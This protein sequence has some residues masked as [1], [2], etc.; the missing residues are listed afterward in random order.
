[1][2]YPS[3]PF[4][5]HLMPK[6]VRWTCRNSLILPYA[7]QTYS[8]YIQPARGFVQPECAKRISRFKGVRRLC[9]LHDL[10]YPGMCQMVSDPIN[11]ASEKYTCALERRGASPT[12]HVA[13]HLIVRCGTILDS[14]T[15]RDA[16]THKQK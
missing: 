13:A 6:L 5:S 7:H 9:T 12:I 16:Q 3:H 1:M 15:H 4:P 2:I 8:A 14:T 11:S 10:N